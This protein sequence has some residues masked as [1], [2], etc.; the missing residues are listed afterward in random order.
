MLKVTDRLFNM[1]NNMMRSGVPGV[2]RVEAE[3][4]EMEGGRD[5]SGF[6]Q[7][8]GL[9]PNSP[10]RARKKRQLENTQITREKFH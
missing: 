5:M 1:D 10:S 6:R 8:I 4:Q 3:R 9:T 7:K 2:G